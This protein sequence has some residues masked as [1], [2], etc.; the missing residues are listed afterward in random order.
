MSREHIEKIKEVIR[1]SSM[2]S[3]NYP[4]CSFDE[5]SICRICGHHK[6]FHVFA[7]GISDCHKCDKHNKKILEEIKSQIGKNK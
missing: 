4:Y 1:G 2:C 5:N 7:H 3:K 6:D